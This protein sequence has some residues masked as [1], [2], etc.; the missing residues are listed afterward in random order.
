MPARTFEGLQN[1]L[2]SWFYMEV[3]GSPAPAECGWAGPSLGA[4][5][6]AIPASAWAHPGG[7]FAGVPDAAAHTSRKGQSWNHASLHWR[8]RAR[9]RCLDPSQADRKPT[10]PSKVLKLAKITR[11]MKATNIKARN[12][13]YRV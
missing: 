7:W 2:V 4:A 9:A 1:V 6:G 8:R 3:R 5:A 10:L 12:E 13:T 11:H